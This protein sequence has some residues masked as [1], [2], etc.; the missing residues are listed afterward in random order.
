MVELS[1]SCGSD[2]GRQFS[3][4]YI[5]VSKVRS[6]RHQKQPREHQLDNYSCYVINEFLSH[7]YTDALLRKSGRT[8][9]KTVYRRP[10]PSRL[11]LL[12]IQACRLYFHGIKVATIKRKLSFQKREGES[13]RVMGWGGSNIPTPWQL[14]NC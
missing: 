6:S 13:H 3:C 8:V 1:N 5:S 14:L 11:D 4:N 7:V 10:P 9:G 12:N 2:I